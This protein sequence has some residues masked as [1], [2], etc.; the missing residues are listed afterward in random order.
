MTSEKRN[1][2]ARILKRLEQAILLR[3]QTYV[4]MMEHWDLP[5]KDKYGHKYIKICMRVDRIQST[6]SAY[7]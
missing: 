4:D 3:R 7:D 6:L 2:K 5:D 1:E